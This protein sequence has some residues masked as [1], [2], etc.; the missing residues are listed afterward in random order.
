VDVTTLQAFVAVADTASFSLAGERLFLTQPAVS[1]RIAALEA[2]LNMRLFD[3][4]GRRVLLTE[5]GA[6]LLPRARRILA[7]LEDSRQALS[8]LAG[9]VAGTLSLATSHH[10]GLHRLPPVLREY[11]ARYPRVQLDLRFMDSEL[12]CGAVARGEVELGIVTLPPTEEPTLE[13]RPLWI[14]D[15]VA[16]VGREHPLA[17]RRDALTAAELA[18][19]PAI[20]PGEATFTRRLI[21]AA[22]A[23]ESLRV[24]FSTNYLE[25][26]KMLVSVGLGWS[27]LPEN[28]VDRELMALAVAG[29]RVQRVLGLVR[30]PERTPSNAGRALIA[31]LENTA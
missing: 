8:N 18:G 26:I 21:D 20:L 31:V 12:A 2:E 13:R 9:Q 29:V 11:A 6:M 27:L 22:F 3:R 23:P 28:M 15:L 14:D 24:A 10:I 25:T 16:V 19:F 4:L 1:K 30:H 7:E 5:A 17:E